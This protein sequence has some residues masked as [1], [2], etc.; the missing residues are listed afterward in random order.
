MIIDSHCHAWET[1]PY[2]PPAPDPDSRGRVEQLLHEMDVN[3]VD[4]ALIVCAQIEHNPENNAYVAEQVARVPERLHQLVDLDSVW[5]STYHAP[6]SA[7][8]LRA[9][10]A[11]WPIKGFTHYL[12]RDD[13][14]AWLTSDEGLALF[15]AAADLGLLASLSCYPHQHPAIRRAAERYPE[16]PV[17]CHHLG[18]IS[19]SED[20]PYPLLK[21][22]LA[23]AKLPNIYIKLSGFAY[24]AEV[25]WDFPYRAVQRIIRAE[26]EHFGPQQMC[27]GS[28]YPVVR[29]YMTYRQALEA[30]RSH[31]DFVSEADKT[32]ILG[33][34]L[35]QLLKICE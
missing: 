32:W 31:C 9:L 14:G 10:A 4:Q 27:W 12:A 19:A 24:A 5:S 11:L 29:F 25:K 8:R 3:G 17:L 28:D 21:A 22:V 15:Q 1:W 26:Y 20:P 35:A 6:G 23:S 2:Q 13:D 16:V 30:F 33:G 34:T 18:H 7:E